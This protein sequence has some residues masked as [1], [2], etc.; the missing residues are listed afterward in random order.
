MR[1]WLRGITRRIIRPED[2]MPLLYFRVHSLD[3][4]IVANN[5]SLFIK[6][7]AC[8]APYGKQ[9]ISFVL[10][11]DNVLMLFYSYLAPQLHDT[12]I[13]VPSTGVWELFMSPAHDQLHHS[14]NPPH[15][16]CNL[17]ASLDFALGDAGAGVVIGGVGVE[18]DFRPLEHAQE[19]AL[20]GEQPFED[21]VA[22]CVAG[23]SLEDAVE[24]GAQLV[25]S[26]R[27]GRQ[28]VVLQLA[29][30]PQDHPP[31]ELDGVALS[32]V[33]GNELVDE[34]LGV[35]PARRMLADTE[36]PGLVGDDDGAP[37]EALLFD[38]PSAASCHRAL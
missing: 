4:L 22:G 33:G 18:G 26:L 10:L 19:F 38:R 23:S 34:P 28:L 5:L 17:G 20:S 11:Y 37:D 7:I 27:I 24:A 3:S 13:W 30:E 36:L 14:A 29:I 8:A 2:L 15:D 31:R 16:N 21:A 1:G 9:A 6:V 25:G 12:Q 32:V 35:H